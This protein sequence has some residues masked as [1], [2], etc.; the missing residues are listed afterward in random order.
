MPFS[1]FL[2]IIISFIIVLLAI[3]FFTLLE[4]KVLGY[5]QIRKG[6]NKVGIMGLPQPLADALKLLRK[7]QSKPS[8]SNL[9]PFLF[10]PVMSLFL[11]LL[12]WYLYPSSYPTHFFSFGVIFFLCISSLNVYTTLIAGWRSNS[13]YALLGALRSIAQT[14]SYEVRIALILL[15]VLILFLRFDLTQILLTNSSWVILLLIPSFLTWFAT[16]LAE[17]NRTPFD[18][19]EGESELVSGFNTEYRA[20]TFTLIFMAEYTNIIFIRI[21]TAVFFLGA[22]QLPFINNLLFLLKTTFIAFLFLWVR[23]S[24]PRIRY[25]RLIRLTWKSFLP[26]S[27]AIL[28]LLCPISLYLWCC[29]GNERITLMTLTTRKIPPSPL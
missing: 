10:T 6:P 17:T 26:F 28:I 16:T 3:A 12:L 24:F 18:F 23:A 15:G 11:A 4:R 21:L 2:N 20:G 14:I 9:L 27:L 1:P 29:A 19:A 7:E 5:A 8:L 22:I 25:D 13:K